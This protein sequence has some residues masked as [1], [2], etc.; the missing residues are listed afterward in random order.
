[1]SRRILDW[2]TEELGT[3]GKSNEGSIEKYEEAIR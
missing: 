1:M 2:N 3:C